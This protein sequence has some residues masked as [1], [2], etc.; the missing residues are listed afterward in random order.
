[1][2]VEPKTCCEGIARGVL[3]VIVVGLVDG[4]MAIC[5]SGFLFSG[6]EDRMAKAAAVT[7]APP[8]APRAANMARVDLDM[9][10]AVAAAC[11]ARGGI[12]M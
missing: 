6:D 9:L 10:A 2:G 5:D 4:A 12:Y 7:A 8:V 3:E 11:D 1:M